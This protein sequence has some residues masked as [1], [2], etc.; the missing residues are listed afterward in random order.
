MSQVNICLKIAKHLNEAL[1]NAI[2]NNEQFLGYKN[3]KEYYNY[4]IEETIALELN[5]SIIPEKCAI[6]E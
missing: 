1:K 5:I 4:A 6:D 2:K 3:L